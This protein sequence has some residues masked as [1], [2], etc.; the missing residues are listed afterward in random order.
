[1]T[2]EQLSVEQRTVLIDAEKHSAI[3]LAAEFEALKKEISD[4]LLSTLPGEISLTKIEETNFLAGFLNKLSAEIYLL[5]FPLSLYIARAQ[6]RVVNFAADSL[7]R[8]LPSFK[9]S[10][11]DPDKEAIQKLINRTQRGDSL[12]KAF[13]RLAEPVV[14][15]AKQELIEGFSLGESA[16]QI[17]RRIND[18]SE[19]GLARAMTIS[20][21]ETNEAYRAASREFY[22]DASIKQY[23]WLSTLDVRTCFICWLLHGRKFNSKFKVT[24]HPNCR[25]VV[26][27]VTKNTQEVETGS[28]RFEKLETSYQRQILGEKRF[29]LYRNGVQ[30]HSFV[31]VKTTDEFGLQHFIRPLS[32]F[33]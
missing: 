12:Q 22:D 20:R 32:D 1:M 10:I 8:F 4:Y 33:E 18:V 9:T 21:T 25:C 14:L 13:S 23:I 26:C 24:A 3:L 27:P 11:F 16:P 29:E 2:P 15:R 6:L 31:G 17:S 5:S 28:S 7:K 30:F 19:I